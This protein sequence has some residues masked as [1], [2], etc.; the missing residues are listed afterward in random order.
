MTYNKNVGDFEID[1]F[2]MKMSGCLYLLE[3]LE[4]VTKLSNC[5]YAILML[6]DFCG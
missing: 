2:L 1:N 6:H 4:F 5:L 3:S